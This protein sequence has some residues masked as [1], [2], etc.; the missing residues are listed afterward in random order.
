MAAVAR[1][2]PFHG[3][4]SGKKRV[5]NYFWKIRRMYWRNPLVRVELKERLRNH[6]LPSHHKD[7]KEVIMGL[8]V[9][10]ERVLTI[11]PC[12]KD[13]ELWNDIGKSFLHELLHRLD[14]KAQEVIIRKR[15]EWLWKE[16]SG[17]QRNY[18]YICM[19]SKLQQPLR[20]IRLKATI[21]RKSRKQ[22]E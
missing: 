10:S 4:W 22:R 3:E 20:G 18:L 11:N 16:F 19:F 14:W 9:W 1:R 13:G 8:W 17:D 6:T 12:S 2:V 5:D 15:E 21:P 7:S